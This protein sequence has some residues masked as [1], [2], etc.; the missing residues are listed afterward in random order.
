MEP[1]ID[2][3]DSPPTKLRHVFIIMNPKLATKAD[4]F[5]G[6]RLLGIKKIASAHASKEALMASIITMFDAS[7]SGEG[8]YNASGH[9]TKLAKQAVRDGWMPLLLWVGMAPLTR[10]SMAC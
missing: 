9:A 5:N 1:S 8:I 6:K 3:R 2:V 10:S 7:N 4:H